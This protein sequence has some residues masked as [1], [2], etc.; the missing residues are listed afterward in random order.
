VRLAY[1]APAEALAG[2]EISLEVT[3]NGNPALARIMTDRELGEGAAKIA[4]WIGRNYLKFL[5]KAEYAYNHGMPQWL[6]AFDHAFSGLHF[7]RL[8]LGR[9]KFYHFRIWYRDELAEYVQS[10][11]LDPKALHR[12][13][14]NA[15][16]VRRM[17]EAHVHG[18]RNHTAEISN[19]L[20]AELTQRLLFE[21]QTGNSEYT[22]RP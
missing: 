14:L 18:K 8:F 5:F 21:L 3:R 22:W 10:I 7:E 4:S 1:Q 6:A 20:T 12:S 15:P 11:L 16:A 17:V 19:L 2:N 9:H 13:Y